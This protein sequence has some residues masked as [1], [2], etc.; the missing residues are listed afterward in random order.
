MT[1]EQILSEFDKLPVYQDEFVSRDDAEN[2]T[3]RIFSKYQ[4]ELREKIE[5]MKWRVRQPA[6]A[7]DE[8]SVVGTDALIYV[9]SG[10]KQTAETH[11]N[12]LDQVIKLIK[13]NV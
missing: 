3:R 8:A 7:A 9:G 6:D 13:K 10:A 5:R 1:L 2:L 12:A 4:E 11:N